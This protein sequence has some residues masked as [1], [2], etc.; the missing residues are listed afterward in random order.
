MVGLDTD[1]LDL[2]PLRQKTTRE[3]VRK[4]L[5]AG[6]ARRWEMMDRDEDSQQGST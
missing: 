6:D 5:S 1:D 3:A 4:E 2:K